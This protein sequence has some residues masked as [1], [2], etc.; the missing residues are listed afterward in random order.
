MI[1]L[2]KILVTTDMSDYSLAALEYAVSFGLLYSSR[3]F[4]LHVADTLPPVLS[5]HGPDLEGDVYRGKAED[6]A[7]RDLHEFIT[8]HVDSGLHVTPVV[9]VGVPADEIVR[10]ARDEGI[11]IIVMATHGRTG[12]RHIVVGS[13]AEHVVRNATVPV[14][15]V[16]PGTIRDSIIGKEDIE[17][18][19]HLA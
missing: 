13:V 14:L 9:R 12:L 6:D 11:D 17:K 8:R 10:F 19:L 1:N 15:T 3:I 16:K 4:L 7:K 2:R 5:L 18:D